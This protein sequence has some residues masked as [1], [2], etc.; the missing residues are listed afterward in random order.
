MVRL[1]KVK[2]ERASDAVFAILRESILDQTFLPGQRLNVKQLAE[3]M[4][5]SLTPVK[6]AVNR[7]VSEGLVEL[8]PRSGTY[9]STLSPKDVAE[10]LAVRRAL[11]WLA[12]ESVVENAT[13][14]DL[15]ELRALEDALEQPVTS[16][17]ERQLHE[18]KNLEFHQKL[19][20][21]SGNRKMIEIYSSLNAHI[22]VARVH[23]SSEGWERRIQDEA[24]EHRRIL[25][26]LESR[27]VRNLQRAL[28][29]HI[30]RGAEALVRDLSRKAQQSEEA[31]R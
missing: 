23:Y 27:N 1:A 12:A 13:A 10:T 30:R 4:E 6:D 5:V 20:E 16:E 25:D 3:K 2:L 7:L 22:K 29:E 21:L 26:A 11:E 8:R 19:I 28:N 14:S 17:R 24:V 15:A 31:G 18:R 9:V